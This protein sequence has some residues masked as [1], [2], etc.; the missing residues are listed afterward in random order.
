MWLVG[1]ADLPLLMLENVLIWETVYIQL[2]A[3]V[4]VTYIWYI[5]IGS[6]LQCT[7]KSTMVLTSHEK[8]SFKKWAI[9]IFQMMRIR[10]P[11]FKTLI[12]YKN[13]VFY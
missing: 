9:N 8:Y 12:F 4:S 11:I 5:K 6:F 3:I 10:A 2:S 13:A 7:Q 1:G